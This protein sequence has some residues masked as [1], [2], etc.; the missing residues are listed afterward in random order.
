MTYTLLHVVCGSAYY[1]NI[2]KM[3]AAAYT[4]MSKTSS[5]IN[6]IKPQLLYWYDRYMR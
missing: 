2:S 6:M 4:Y 3:Q 5:Y 1:I